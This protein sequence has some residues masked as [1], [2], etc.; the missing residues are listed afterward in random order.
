MLISRRIVLALTLAIAMTQL[1]AA[2]VLEQVPDGA[3][4]VAKVRNLAETNTKLAAFFKDLGVDQLSPELADPLAAIKKHLNI[5][6]GLDEKG[7]I[8][9]IYVDPSVSSVDDDHSM[10]ILVP[11]TDYK[12]FTGNFPEAKT[13][14]DFTET[15]FGHDPD[16][17]YITPWGK[18]AAISPSKEL[19]GKKPAGGVKLTGLTA[20]EIANK[21]AIFYVNMAAVRKM[22]LPKLKDQRENL[23][24][25]ATRSFTGDKEKYV[26]LVKAM[27]NQVLNIAEGYLNDANSATYGIS[28]GA[29]G[30]NGTLMSEFEPG[31]YS[32]DLVTRVKNGDGSM[33]TGLPNT[34]YIAYGGAVA[35]PEVSAK[36]IDDF[37]GPIM[38]EVSALGDEGKAITQYIDS[39]KKMSTAIKGGSFGMLIP[40][41]MLGQDSIFQV[42]E[43]I[44]GDSKA[45]GDAQKSLMDNQ[46]ELMKILQPNGE[47]QQKVTFTPAVKTVD[48]VQLDQMTTEFTGDA[49]TPQAQQMQ[50]MMTMMYGPGGMKML[51][52]SIDNDSRIITI[53]TSDDTTQ[54]LITA[55]K[56]KD[57]ALG[58]T[59]GVTAVTAELPSSKF[60][61]MY[62]AVDNLITTGLKYAGAMGMNLPI[63]LPP[64]Q[65]PVGVS[66]GTEGTAVRVDTFVPTQLVKSITAAVIQ[67]Q[68]QMQGGGQGGGGM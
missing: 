36:I 64:N 5:S 23:I 53:A 26:P 58:K 9:F 17:S 62:F 16:P 45:I 29:N 2:Q 32:G 39:F 6:Q 43:T 30:I 1:A 56:T 61:V 3:L 7:E 37:T 57:A 8:A 24:G 20:K 11:V 13:E 63:N 19:L 10:M 31:T 18:F 33:L 49:T 22:A 41:G 12:A 65:P 25:E 66:M 38:K 44:N 35:T 28:F 67:F 54:Q 42:V 27:V 47:L 4:V 59:D 40:S 14:G 46:Q 60:A 15:K 55:A 52:G 34:K 48:G 51:T 50:Q 68:M 21:D